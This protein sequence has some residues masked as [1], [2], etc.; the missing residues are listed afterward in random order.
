LK[1]K[2]TKLKKNT[3]TKKLLKNFGLTGHRSK[4]ASNNQSVNF[5]CSQC[6]KEVLIP[7]EVVEH[8]DFLDGGDSLDPPKFTCEECYSEM[9]P[10]YFESHTD[11]VYDNST[12]K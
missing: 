8:F 3:H 10:E 9:V 6:G 11:I 4:K 5:I 12:Q 2:R 7:T 1:K